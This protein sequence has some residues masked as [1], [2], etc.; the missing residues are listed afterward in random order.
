MRTVTVWLEKADRPS[1][2]NPESNFG[3]ETAKLLPGRKSKTG[4]SF[5]DSYPVK[6]SSLDF[7]GNCKAR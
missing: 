2:A 6:S 7:V 3:G 5:Y 4:E 1:R